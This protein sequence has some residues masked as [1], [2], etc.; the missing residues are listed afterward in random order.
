MLN[1][2]NFTFIVSILGHSLFLGVPEFRTGSENRSGK[3]VMDRQ[4]LEKVEAVKR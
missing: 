4:F 2:P 3:Q 1:S